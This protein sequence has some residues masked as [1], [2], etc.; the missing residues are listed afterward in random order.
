LLRHRAWRGRAYMVTS[1]EPQPGGVLCRATP[2]GAGRQ[3]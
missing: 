3:R 1:F 2:H